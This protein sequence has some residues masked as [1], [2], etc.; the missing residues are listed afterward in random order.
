VGDP[1][2]YNLPTT[3]DA[4]GFAVTASF[5]GPKWLSLDG[6]NLIFSVKLGATKKTDAGNSTV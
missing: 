2:I 5:V 4:N 1:L 6:K 3:Y